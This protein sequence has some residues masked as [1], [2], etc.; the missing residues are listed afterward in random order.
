MYIKEAAELAQNYYPSEYDI[1]EMCL[2]C[3]EVSSMLMIED[4]NIL[5]SETM[6]TDKNSNIILPDGVG[7]ENVISVTA[8]GKILYKDNLKDMDRVLKN[9]PF[10]PVTVVYLMPHTPIRFA[11]Y[12][13]EAE[14]DTDN[15]KIILHKNQFIKGDM[16]NVEIDGTNAG[17]FS[18]ENIE[19]NKNPGPEI[20]LSV[21]ENGLA[22][23]ESKSSEN[24]VINRLITDKTVC[25]APYDG[26]YVDYILAKIGMYQR[27][28]EMYNQYMTAFNSRL[29]AYKRW[30]INHMPASG[31]KLTNWW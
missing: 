4:K 1:K 5:V 24:V 8:G 29:G 31:G 17:D 22:N 2:W 30:L 16:I 12:R 7:F 27:D 13:G 20:V 21:N 11:S 25:N 10:S 26:M 3:D 19:I 9:T 28:Y 23:I 18:I 15:S 6:Y 14:F